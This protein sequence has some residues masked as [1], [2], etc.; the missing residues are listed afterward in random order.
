MQP[1]QIVELAPLLFLLAAEQSLLHRRE[2]VTKLEGALE[3]VRKLEG[4]IWDQ[5][6]PD[7]EWLEKQIKAEHLS[8]DQG[9]IFGYGDDSDGFSTSTDYPFSTFLSNLAADFSDL[10]KFENWRF[11]GSPSYYVCSEAAAEIAGGVEPI[12]D[13]ILRGFVA[14]HEMPKEIH[15][16]SMTKER[17]YWALVT[18]IAFAKENPGAI[19]TELFATYVKEINTSEEIKASL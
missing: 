17:I 3:Q 15:E 1:S 2:R 7:C 19:P 6:V 9:D 4:E 8:I 12:A 5:P 11:D 18:F 13:M 14:L 16:P 10:A